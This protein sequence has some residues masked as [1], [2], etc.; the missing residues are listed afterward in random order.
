MPFADSDAAPAYRQLGVRF[1]V[2]RRV[3]PATRVERA[4]R[5]RAA[6]A[7]EDLDDASDGV[8]AI[9]HTR[10]TAHDLDSLDIV[11]GE[12][13][14]VEGAAGIVHRDTVDQHLRV[15]ALRAAR[16]ERRR[17]AE[18]SRLH[19]RHAGHLP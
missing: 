6:M 19:D 10:R 17:S 7:R 2:I 15:V 12:E 8:R 13:T 18:G 14:E 5:P 3:A 4:A 16:E 1:D 9:Q 11:E